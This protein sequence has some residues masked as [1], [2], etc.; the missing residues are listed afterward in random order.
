MFGAGTATKDVTNHATHEINFA[1]IIINIFFSK[2]TF[3]LKNP[4]N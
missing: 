3:S 2:I 4:V 1:E